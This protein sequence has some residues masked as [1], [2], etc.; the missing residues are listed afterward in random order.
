MCRKF[1]NSERKIKMKRILISCESLVLHQGYEVTGC[2]TETLRIPREHCKLLAGPVPHHIP[3]PIRFPLFNSN[4][5]LDSTLDGVNTYFYIVWVD[6]VTSSLVFR[7]TICYQHR[8]LVATAEF[9]FKEQIWSCFWSRWHS[10][11]PYTDTKHSNIL[12]ALKLRRK[13]DR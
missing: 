7:K 11:L 5:P 4:G 6:L 8:C 9:V 3:T 1:Q 13:K 2:V 10:Q 12:I